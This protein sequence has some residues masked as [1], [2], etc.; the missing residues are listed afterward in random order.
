MP[1]T[2]YSLRPTFLRRLTPPFALAPMSFHLLCALALPAAAWAQTAPTEPS[3]EVTTPAKPAAPTSRAPAAKPDTLNRVEVTG[4]TQTDTD[5]RR[6]STAAKIIVGR[7]EIE[8]YGD[9]T[10]G[11]LLKRLPGITTPGRP[12]RGGGPRMRG[13]GGGY[14]QIM[15]DGQRVA[16]GFSLDDLSP[17]QIERI[18][19]LRAPTAETGARAIAGTI[20]IITRGGYTRKVNDLRIGVGLENDNV[21]P[22]FTWSRNDTLDDMT[23]NFSVSGFQGKRS[24][25]SSSTVVGDNLVTGAQ[26]LQRDSSQ[27]SGQRTGLHANSRLQWRSPNGGSL[28]LMPMVVLS[29][30]YNNGA[31]TLTRSDGLVPYDRSVNGSDSQSAMLRLNGQWVHQLDAGGSV[32]WNGGVGRVLSDSHS[33]RQNFGSQQGQNTLLDTRSQQQDTSLTSNAKWNVALDSE[34]NLVTGA[35]VELNRREEIAKT[36]GVSDATLA[37]LDGSL[38]ASATRAALFV[39][40]EWSINQQWAAH[41]G[42]RWEGI[43]TVGSASGDQEV[44]NTSNVL[45]PL[46]HAVWK[47]DP[48][49]KDQV[50]FSLTRS[51]RSPDLG[52]LIARP[53][54]NSRYLGRGSNVEMYPDRAG[55]PDLKPEL[56][57]G[58][59]V[60]FEHYIEGGLLSANVFYRTISN[61]IRSR[62]ALESVSWADEPR[63][64]SRPQNIGNAT[65]QGVELEA[66]FR[67]SDLW[68]DAPKVDVRANASIFHSRVE[69]ITG[70]NNRLAEQPDGTLNLGADYKIPTSPLTI[71]GNFN[72][73]PGYT[74]QLTDDQTSTQGDK[75][76]LELFGLWAFKP[77]YQLRV[78]AS[79][80]VPRDYVSSGTLLTTN[81]LGQSVRE[82]TTNTAPTA[83]NLQVRFEMKL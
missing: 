58:L 66:K 1:S 69:G 82:T 35:E 54:I 21:M 6:Q 24:N 49:S 19:I 61:L 30:G 83:V 10:M 8:K 80:L 16:P 59:D 12:G 32:H 14:T 71:G 37:D 70:P 22:G 44:S 18:E 75:R 60:A 74:T 26:T 4:K 41:A 51:Y 48:Q 57:S 13:M 9:S 43:R 55:N 42:V 77:G 17:E 25:D 45:T 38:S 33:S 62:T 72:W 29:K 27:S 73:T 63:W 7:D 3:P 52:N 81:A 76:A 36:S 65:T 5:Q 28:V 34:H 64:V 23:Y 46:L 31:S 15:I 68:A 11:E 53:S 67:L 2:L 20:N 56:A 79:N 78:S 39:Q 50:R 40:D 47:F